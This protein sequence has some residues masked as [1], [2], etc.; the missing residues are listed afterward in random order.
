[1]RFPAQQFYLLH[2]YNRVCFWMVERRCVNI[3][4]CSVFLYFT[5]R[6]T[7][8]HFQYR[9]RKL[10]HQNHDWWVFKTARAIDNRCFFVHENLFPLSPM[11]V[12]MPLGQVTNSS[13]YFSASIISSSVAFCCPNEIFA[14]IVSLNNCC[15]VSL[16]PLTH[17]GL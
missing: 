6:L 5:R 1:M 17:A 13:V 4:R 14:F 9:V 11:F 10:L 15:P 3:N 12:C 8:L 16:I 7:E 2:D